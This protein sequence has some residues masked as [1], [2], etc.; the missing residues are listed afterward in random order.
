MFILSFKIFTFI[1][2]IHFLNYLL[3]ILL[4]FQFLISKN[5]VLVLLL[6]FKIIY[7]LV[8][9]SIYDDSKY[10]YMLHYSI[11]IKITV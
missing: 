8:M 11:N 7:K 2:Y 6:N 10:K 3:Y 5:I 4:L 9:F 1:V